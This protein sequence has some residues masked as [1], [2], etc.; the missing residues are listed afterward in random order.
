[1]SSLSAPG[2]GYAGGEQIVLT[3]TGFSRDTIVMLDEAPANVLNVS[4]AELIFE[5]PA[6]LESG[7]ITVTVHR[8]ADGAQVDAGTVERSD[9]LPPTVESVS[10]AS[11]ARDLRTDTAFVVVFSE[12]IV[13]YGSTTEEIQQLGAASLRLS[14]GGSSVTVVYSTNIARDTL[15]VRPA[16]LDEATI[17]QLEFTGITDLNGQSS[18]VSEN[19]TYEY[20]AVDTVAP[21][22]DTL[23]TSPVSIDRGDTVT[24]AVTL[25]ENAQGAYLEGL[26]Q[27]VT[28]ERI[29]FYLS[30]SSSFDIFSATY[31]G[32]PEE[33][34]FDGTTATFT[35]GSFDFAGDYAWDFYFYVTAA[36]ASGNE[37]IPV[38]LGRSVTDDSEV[39]I[40]ESISTPSG[41]S[42]ILAPGGITI[43]VAATASDNVSVRQVTFTVSGAADLT[44]VDRDAPYNLSFIANTVG[45][46]TVTAVAE[47]SSGNLSSGLSTVITVSQD[48]I[49]PTITNPLAL[50][51]GKNGH[52]RGTVLALSATVEDETSLDS[53]N[54]YINDQP[55]T[56]LVVNGSDYSFDYPV[57]DAELAG[58]F[59]FTVE[60]FDAANNSSRYDQTIVLV[61]NNPQI[62]GDITILSSAPYYEGTDLDT[63]ITVEAEWR[64]GHVFLQLGDA[65]P[66][67]QLATVD[68]NYSFTSTI[69]A[70]AGG[71]DLVLKA[72]VEDE[73][74][75]TSPVVSKTISI[76]E[77]AAPFNVGH[78]Q[79]G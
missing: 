17:Y 12:P 75:A 44:I 69:P 35:I 71:V 56:P 14:S 16:V 57:G 72:W 15:I 26:Q 5:M 37:A 78:S 49:D 70:N 2:I 38:S 10:P 58:G 61:D 27:G 59:I 68:G 13:P 6:G 60:A 54:F 7:A 63:E 23:I 4:S 39:P 28:A 32:S 65:A 55:L 40:V 9:I 50:E 29:N 41:S 1:M 46:Y 33:S 36:D 31:L 76:L 45:A 3:G 64:P 66:Q 22:L 19:F 42:F 62:I 48:S 53:V 24:L 25:D 21:T 77:D 67:E 74:G 73:I 52:V 18:E 51:T 79:S 11:G 30:Q 34:D 43:P 47:D 8:P 20:M